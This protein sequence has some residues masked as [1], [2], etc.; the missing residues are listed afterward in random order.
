M[1]HAK[2]IQHLKTLKHACNT[3]IKNGDPVT[4][5]LEGKVNPGKKVAEDARL[6]GFELLGPY[7][8]VHTPTEFKCNR[9]NNHSTIRWEYLKYSWYCKGC[10]QKAK[11]L[12]ITDAEIDE[13]LAEL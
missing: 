3:A 4:P 5:E 1:T 7:K 10:R 11:S 9:C 2:K 8:N 6:G 12:T 13:I